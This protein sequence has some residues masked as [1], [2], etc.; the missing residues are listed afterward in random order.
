MSNY[1]LDDIVTSPTRIS[2]RLNGSSST[3]IDVAL[4]NNKYAAAVLVTDCVFSDK[5]FVSITFPFSRKNN[6][7][8]FEN[9]PKY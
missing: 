7:F 4:C 1:D 3:L 5:K 6:Q 9:F 8:I 2:V